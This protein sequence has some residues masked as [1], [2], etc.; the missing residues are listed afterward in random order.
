MLFSAGTNRRK[1]FFII[2]G[3]KGREDVSI[4]AISTVGP[5]DAPTVL[6]KRHRRILQ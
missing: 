2:A 6:H 5:Y 3:M 4:I 1:A